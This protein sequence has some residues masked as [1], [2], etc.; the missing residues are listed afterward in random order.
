MYRKKFEG[1]DCSIARSLDQVGEWWS[2]LIVRECT[3]GTSRFDEFQRRL[4][5]A[6]NVLTNRLNHLVEHGILDK[7]PVGDSGRFFEYRLTPKGDELYP[8][9]VALLQWGDKW[10]GDGKGGPIELL[11]HETGKPVEWMGP[12]AKDGPVLGYRGVRLKPGV[13]AADSTREV[14]DNR[15][16]VILGK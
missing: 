4:G 3:L 14:I 2:L 6:R 8:V 11:D 7:L 1:M 13:R 10:A 16:R 15:N 12:R 5:I 9:L